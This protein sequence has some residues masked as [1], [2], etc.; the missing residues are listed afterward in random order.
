MEKKPKKELEDQERKFLI[1]AQSKLHPS[2]V[3]PECGEL[4]ELRNNND[5]IYCIACDTLLDGNRP[6]KKVPKQRIPQYIRFEMERLKK[7]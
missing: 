3:C 4:F 6:L 2:D 5:Y 7:K 1:K